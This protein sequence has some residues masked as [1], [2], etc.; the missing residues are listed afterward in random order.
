M[1]L[2]EW[3]KPST[4][5]TPNTGRDV[6]PQG[7]SFIAG[8]GAKWHSHRGMRFSSFLQNSAHSYRRT[9]NHAP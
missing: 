3:P 6:A 1:L 8:G 7:L 2:L 9:S 5:T 4:K